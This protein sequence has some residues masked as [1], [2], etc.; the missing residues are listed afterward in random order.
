M[1][2]IKKTMF[3]FI[4]LASTMIPSVNATSSKTIYQN[5]VAVLMYHHLANNLHN[6][7]INA[8]TIP[9]S[10]FNSQLS[11]L[12]QNGFDFITL[13]QFINYLNGGSVP[14]NAVLVTF[15]DG[16]ES[17]DKLAYPILKSKRIPSV[18][19]VV[20]SATDNKHFGYIPHM[21]HQELE[22]VTADSMTEVQCHTNNLHYLVDKRHDALTA[23]LKING[24]RETM[25][26]Y[27]KRIL[28]DI[29]LCKQQ[30]EPINHSPIDTFAYPY[31]I[32]DQKSE[33]LL[34]QSDIH[35][36]FTVKDGMATRNTNLMEIP[37]I[38]GGNPFITAADLKENIL[39]AANPYGKSALIRK[40]K[41]FAKQLPHHKSFWVLCFLVLML[42][43][44]KGYKKFQNQRS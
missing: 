17:F 38:N 36:A 1:I 11:Y 30:L 32:H 20:T 21:T 5:E 7:K 43:G 29:H 40:A 13:R 42:I 31:G 12:Q 39:M 22:Q 9:T 8:D 44:F 28:N 26:Q 3:L 16:Y 37:R 10:L 14:P 34:H 23:F 35:Y 15:D 18:D 4:A 27:Q 33:N 24:K 25:E 19:F 41:L 6:L 2:G